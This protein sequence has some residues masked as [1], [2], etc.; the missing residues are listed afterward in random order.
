[1]SD[2]P[3]MTDLLNRAAEK[4]AVDE[5]NAFPTLRRGTYRL[6]ATKWEL[7]ENGELGDFPGK[8]MINLQIEVSED[9]KRRGVIFE[10]ITPETL[11][12]PGTNRLARPT[13][14]FGNYLK[15][16]GLPAD[17]VAQVLV[18]K[19]IMQYPVDGFI[20]EAFSEEGGPLHFY[21]TEEERKALASQVGLKAR[22]WLKKVYPVK[23]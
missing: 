22:N 11:R 20:D 18:E 2:T 13:S 16:Y 3:T 5:A 12:K 14:L 9:G 19:H 6:Q 7:K 21:K 23:G 8:P 4:Q 10:K 17:T 1:M 15:A